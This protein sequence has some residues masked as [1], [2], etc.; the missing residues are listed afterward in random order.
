MHETDLILMSLCIFV[1]TLFALVVLF[2]PRQY[3]EYMRWVTLL[4][5][6]V[7]FVISTFLFVDYLNL[8]GRNLD[9]DGRA[10]ASTRLLDRAN[11]LTAKQVGN[12]AEPPTSDDLLS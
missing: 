1:P 5:T 10:K 8:L 12:A 11:T 7:T 3:A 4:G 9:P 2:I 6:A